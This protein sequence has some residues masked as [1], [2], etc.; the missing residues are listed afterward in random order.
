[1][2]N[3][4]TA[5]D[6][7]PGA[8]GPGLLH[9]NY[10]CDISLRQQQLLSGHDHHHLALQEREKSF[11]VNHLL[12]LPG[13]AHLY[14]EQHGQPERLSS[15]LQRVSQAL[16][17]EHHHRLNSHQLKL[18]EGKNKL[19]FIHNIKLIL[20]IVKIQCFHDRNIKQQTDETKSTKSLKKKRKSDLDLGLTLKSHD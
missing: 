8:G 17:A 5:S 6:E 14:Q 13:Q 18:P 16:S 4:G 2:E 10:N 20:S 11:S 3:I 9:S 15:D 12:E 19:L 1:M 7:G